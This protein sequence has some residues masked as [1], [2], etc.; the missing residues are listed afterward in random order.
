[1]NNLLFSPNQ[2]KDQIQELNISRKS[3]NKTLKKLKLA[4][5]ESIKDLTNDN[6]DKIHKEDIKS[7]E[8]FFK[9]SIR[10]YFDKID[11][12]KVNS[13]II[14]Y[15]RHFINN[16]PD[17][18]NNTI[19]RACLNLNILKTK[20]DRNYRILR[21]G[22]LVLEIFNTKN[23]DQHF[24]ILDNKINDY[25]FQILETKNKKYYFL[26]PIIVIPI[27]LIYVI[28]IL[29]LIVCLYMV[30]FKIIVIDNLLI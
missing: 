25:H 18:S 12:E 8:D 15:I 21:I 4:A 27:L 30:L 16:Y 17:K 23:K 13:K 29:L 14:R 6:F 28:P 3:L 2:P 10:D 22:S 1:M 5:I 26:I 9:D 20:N 24:L 11:K 7:I 19:F